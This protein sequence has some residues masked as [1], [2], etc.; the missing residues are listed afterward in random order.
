VICDT[1]TRRELV[2]SS[3]GERA[4]D[5]HTVTH[6]IALVDRRVKKLRDVTLDQLVEFESLVTEKQFRR[7]HHVVTEIG[8]VQRGIQMLEQGDAAGLGALMNESYRSA[9]YDYGSSSPALDA[10]VEAAVRHPG[11]YGARYSGGGEAGVV[12]ALVDASAVEDFI[13]VTAARYERAV[14]REGTLFPV[15]PAQGAGVFV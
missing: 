1:N 14:Q 7:A 11:C 3:Y 9:R 8:R 4:K 15:E 5:V 6:T 13:A 12:V 2:G 10:M